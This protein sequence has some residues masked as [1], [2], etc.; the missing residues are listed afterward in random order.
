MLAYFSFPVRS[1]TRPETPAI[2]INDISDQELAFRVTSEFDLKIN[3]SDINASPGPFESLEDATT[4][5]GHICD[6]FG[7]C[8]TSLND[9]F[10][11]DL[12]VVLS[13]IFEEC[14]HQDR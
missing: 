8:Q 9:I 12:W 3:Q 4:L 11:P 13:I 2:I 1:A 14:L 10:F 5:L 7:V 6:L